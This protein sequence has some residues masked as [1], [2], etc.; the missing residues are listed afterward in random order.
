MTQLN[1]S[2]Y[3]GA[4]DRQIIYR[5]IG[6]WLDDICAQYPDNE[7]LV[8]RHQDVRWTYRELH[9]KVE[10]LASGLLALGIQPGDRVGIWGPNSAEWALVQYATAKI[11]AIMVCINPAYRLHELEFALNKVQCKALVSAEA[12]KSSRYLE[13]LQTLAPELAQSAPG[14]LQAEKLPDLRTVIRIA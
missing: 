10:Q 14:S 9:K 6:A 5:T 1:Q 7:A 3:C 8:V 4:S 11:G 2:Y 12:F 13:M